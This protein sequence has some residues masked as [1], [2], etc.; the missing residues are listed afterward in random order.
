MSAISYTFATV[1]SIVWT[2]HLIVS[3]HEKMYMRRDD[4][5]DAFDFV[6]DARMRGLRR[7]IIRLNTP[8]DE[9][10]GDEKSFFKTD[11]EG[12]GE[13]FRAF[14]RGGKER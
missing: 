1:L 12:R 5:D 2:L 10:F 11:D 3:W 14:M 4:K 13:G 6:R 9:R 7:P 8:P